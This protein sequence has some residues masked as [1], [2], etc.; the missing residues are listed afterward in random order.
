MIN[1]VTLLKPLFMPVR[2]ENQGVNASSS[3]RKKRNFHSMLIKYMSSA[4][5]LR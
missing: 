3:I 2:V 4:V 1:L 5:M